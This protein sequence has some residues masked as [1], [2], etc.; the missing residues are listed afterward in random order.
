VT[1]RVLGVDIG[2][3]AVK[4]I[5]LDEHG[6]VAA[7]ASIPH[8]G[9]APRPGWSEGDPEAWWRG[10][11][12]ALRRLAEQAPLDGVA[13][14]GVS[15]MV[16]ALLCLDGAGR[17]L[18]PS[19]QQN[20]AR[21]EAEIEWL[22][23][24][25][26]APDFFAATGQPLSQQLVLPRLLWLRTH[27]PELHRRIRRV[28]GSYDWITHRLTGEWSLERNWALESGFWD[29]R[30]RGWYAPALA[31]TEMPEAWLPPVRA[32]HDV[33]GALTPEAA[34]ATGLRA[35][36]RVIAGSADHVAAALA[37]GTGPGELVLKIGGGGDVLYGVDHFAPDP[38]LY[39][40][41]HDLPG[42]FL[43]NGCMVTSGALVKWFAEAFAPDLGEG[44]ARYARLD[45]EA[46]ATPPGADGLVMLPYFLGEKT[47]IFDAGVRGAV[48][49]LTLAHGRGHLF[50]AVLEAVAY[51]FRHHVDVL[52]EG[53]HRIRVVRIMDRGARSPLWR[54]IVADVLGRPIEYAPGADLGS[55]WGVAWVAG[56]AAG[57]WDWERSGTVGTSADPPP[58]VHGP[59]PDH[60]ARYERLYR[61][62][63]G[64]YPTLRGETR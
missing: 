31:A 2:T 62:Y 26:P 55:A 29:A 27:E 33:V 16:P 28:L 8:D 12:G 47:P 30:H 44:E 15:G 48:C 9:L 60:T 19:I 10:A 41:Y 51:G 36:T 23:G 39:I 40:D 46:E 21:T 32:P 61:L 25:L 58:V 59:V 6:R 54:Q 63:R 24:R 38:R 37:A 49:G 43:L 20:D 13:M 4:A 22:R 17:L 50:R 35:G 18:R 42:R 56:V 34:A 53:G 64:L 57:F 14:V 52:V 11:V 7:T 3:T 1:A 45:A 5:A